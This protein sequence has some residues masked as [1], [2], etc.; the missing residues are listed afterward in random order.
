MSS[1]FQLTTQAGSF[2]SPL[3]DQRLDVSNVYGDTG[4]PFWEPVDLN[5]GLDLR[6]LHVPAGLLSPGQ[7]Y[8]W[9][10]R[11]RDRNLLWSPWTSAVS[12]T[13]T[14]A[15]PGPD[16]LAGPVSGSAPLVVRFTDVSGGEPLAW[17]WDFDGDGNEDSS[18]R[19]PVFTYTT[20]GSWSPALT[21]TYADGS[22]TRVQ[23]GLIQVDLPVPAVS[24]RS[25]GGLAWL[26]WQPVPGA[27]YYKVYGSAEGYGPF[28]PEAGGEVVGSSW[29]APLGLGQRCWQVRAVFP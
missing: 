3:L 14:A 7:T 10:V 21:V 2:T 16:F 4:T 11:H 22:R 27:L 12:F 19:D 13:P 6:R 1:Q 28:L 5:T 18:E 15:A 17:S 25:E 9:R 20:P 26:E 23:P 8:R 29:A 24:V